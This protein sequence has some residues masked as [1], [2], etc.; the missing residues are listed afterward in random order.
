MACRLLYIEMDNG[1]MDMLP[2]KNICVSGGNMIQLKEIGVSDSGNVRELLAGSGYADKA[3]AYFLKRT[4]MGSLA[5][6][7]QVAELTGS[8]GDTMKIYLKLEHI[9]YLK[10]SPIPSIQTQLL[11]ME[12]L[13]EHLLN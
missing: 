4:N 7:D 6:A 9:V 10:I 13:R 1:F 3:I 5:D 8:C 12:Y 2:V 11:S